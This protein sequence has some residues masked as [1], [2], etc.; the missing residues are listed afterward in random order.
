MMNKL[1][2]PKR[3]SKSNNLRHQSTKIIGYLIHLFVIFE[4]HKPNLKNVL[5]KQMQKGVIISTIHGTGF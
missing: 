4:Q 2:F 1:N 5:F 3:K